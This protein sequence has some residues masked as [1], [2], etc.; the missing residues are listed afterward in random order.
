MSALTTKNS[1]PILEQILNDFNRQNTAIIRKAKDMV[2]VA[3]SI[4]TK[5]S[6][7]GKPQK[8]Y[9]NSK[10]GK[11]KNLVDNELFNGSNYEFLPVEREN[12]GVNGYIRTVDT[13]STFEGIE[14]KR[15]CEDI[16]T[17]H[18]QGETSMYESSIV[19]GGTTLFKDA[20]GKNEIICETNVQNIEDFLDAKIAAAQNHLNTQSLLNE[21]G[22]IGG[23]INDDIAEMEKKRDVKNGEIKR[24]EY[25]IEEL[26]RILNPQIVQ[27]EDTNEV[28]KEST[29]GEEIME[30]V[31]VSLLSVAKPFIFLGRKIGEGSKGFFNWLGEHCQ[32]LTAFIRKVAMQPAFWIALLFAIINAPF[33][34]RLFDEMFTDSLLVL[35]LTLLCTS[36]FSI[37]PFPLSK[38]IKRCGENP[39]N[40]IKA[41]LTFESVLVSL[42]AVAYPILTSQYSHIYAEAEQAQFVAATAVGLLPTIMACVIG[43]INYFRLK[44]DG[45]VPAIST[46]IESAIS[47]IVGQP[48]E[49]SPQDA[50][51]NNGVADDTADSHKQNTN[52]EVDNHEC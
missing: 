49:T 45:E 36:G 25:N 8:T 38:D 47:E 52:M 7:N 39:D 43:F 5:A 20:H 40:A 27:P 32:T 26:V 3:N 4:P 19:A 31:G 50:E 1:K 46:A 34:H 33:I 48:N 29:T 44:G 12:V 14:F 37:L 23:E 17:S 28:F 30:V 21:I 51:D 18:I 6:K 42:L 2:R 35:V 16:I 10:L 24:L 15:V 9:K 41:R 13:P 11:I 22:S